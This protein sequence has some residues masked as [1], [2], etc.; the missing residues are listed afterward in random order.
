MKTVKAKHD[1]SWYL[2]IFSLIYAI[3]VVIAHR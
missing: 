2:L 3:L 1:Y